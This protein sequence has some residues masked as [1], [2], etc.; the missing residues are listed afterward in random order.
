MVTSF[1]NCY[2]YTCRKSFHSL[3]IARHRAAHRDKREDCLIG[4]SDGV[5]HVHNFSEKPLRYIE[6]PNKS[7]QRT[8]S[9]IKGAR[10]EVVIFDEVSQARE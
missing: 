1:K 10:P 5:V 2:C 6:R 8:P 4:Y 7:V 9:E 3:G